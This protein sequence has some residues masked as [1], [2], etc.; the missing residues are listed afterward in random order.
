MDKKKFEEL[1]LSQEILKGVTDMGFEEATSIQSGTIPLMMTGV[2]LIGQAQTGTGKTAAFGIPLLEMVDAKNKNV[3][4]LV[5]CPTRELA[6]QVAE[7]IGKIGKYKKGIKTLAVYGGQ[8]IDRQIR[9]L[10][11]GA[12]I[13]IGTPGRLIDHIERKTMSLAA[14][15]MV[16][17]DEADEMLNMGFVEDIELILKKAPEKRQ[18]VLF[19]ATMP[20]PI[21][22]ITKRYQKDPQHIKITREIL[23][24]PSIEQCYYE[25]KR[26]TKLEALCRLLDMNEF[27]LS[28]IFCNTKMMVDDLYGH[29]NSRGYLCESL[30]GDKTQ[31]MRDRVMDKVR[32]G[33]VDILIA[34]DVAARGIDVEGIDAVFNYDVPA[35]EEYYVHRIGRTGRAGRTG[36]SFT[37]V[38]PDEI[39]KMRGIMRYAKIKIKQEKIPTKMGMEELRVARFAEKVKEVVAKGGLQHHIK[40][41]EAMLTPDISSTDVAAALMKMTMEKESGSTGT[42]H[43]DINAPERSLSAERGGERSSRF[44]SHNSGSRGSGS[45]GY[46]AG[47]YSR[48]RS[49]DR[50]AGH[51]R[52]KGRDSDITM[53]KIFLS[54]GKGSGA[55]VKDILGAITGET[56]IGGNQ[57]GRIDMQDRNTFVHVDSTQADKVV[58][59]MNG[60][61]I[62]GAK[63][64]AEKAKN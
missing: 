40:S 5:M 32:H 64:F 12:Q 1:N 4:A 24:A 56:G 8:P 62:K 49:D 7:E 61:R 47:S 41:V 25:L 11:A 30:H 38:Y 2:D 17:L 9:A 26:G 21:M 37:F 59:K 31:F 29:L 13:V 42:A 53:T 19:S 45:R 35:D 23:T 20:A 34:T 28:L 58:E 54:V 63:I 43:D 52:S 6:V 44:S 16:V 22:A 10:R 33:K 36:K 51:T 46:G 14:C 18:T 55:Q 39:F 15:A 57:V 27:K 60:K 3:Q 48:G 50:P